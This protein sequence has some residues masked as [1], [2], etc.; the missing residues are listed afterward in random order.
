MLHPQILSLEAVLFKGHRSTQSVTGVVSM[1]GTVGGLVNVAAGGELQGNQTVFN[2]LVTV[3]S[4][5]EHSPGNSPGTQTFAAGLSYESGSILNWELISNSTTGAGTNYDFLSVTGGSLAISA[6]ATINLDFSGSGS[7]VGVWLERGPECDS[8]HR[9]TF[10]RTGRPP[11]RETASV[12]PS[13]AARECS[14][15][16]AH[17]GR[18]P[19]AFFDPLTGLRFVPCSDLIPDDAIPTR[20]TNR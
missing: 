10:G 7:T 14:F 11:D 1:T 17:S 6:G 12:S 4:A 13:F 15:L 3:A 2:G 20:E 8:G 5:A 18:L 19:K 16:Y 9:L